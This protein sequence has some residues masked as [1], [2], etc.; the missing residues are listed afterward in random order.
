V[1]TDDGG[2]PRLLKTDYF[3]CVN[4][5]PAS[6]A[7]DFL[8]PFINKFSSRLGEADEN[9]VFFVE[10]VPAGLGTGDDVTS[11]GAEEAPHSAPS[12]MTGVSRRFINAFHWYDG[13]T[14]FIKQFRPWFNYNLKNG[15]I[16]LG[17]KAVKA[18]YL[19]Q[20]SSH[21]ADSMPSIVGEF[22]LPFDIYKGRAFK[23]GDYAVHEEALS[24][25]YD[26]FDA[27]L[28]GCC[29]WAYSADNTFRWGDLWNNEEFSFVT[30]D[31][32][33][34][35]EE[36]AAC[37]L[38]PR[39]QGGWL[40]PYPAATAGTPLEFTWNRKTKKMFFRYKA[41]PA[42]SAPTEIFIPANLHKELKVTV[43]PACADRPE[44]ETEYDAE[45]FR[46]KIFGGTYDGEVAV[47][48]EEK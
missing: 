44:L 35:T 46:L 16:V 29:I 12:R 38:K 20:I 45:K 5:K 37:P 27:L 47:R 8:K 33:G 39:A 30:R 41:S 7:E 14:M 19:E 18:L 40:R 10:G 6:F 4:G 15:K 2:E 43:T 22:G 28:L 34:R 32:A 24:M 21:I 9:A 25:Y 3:S 23:T 26:A 36:I 42:I 17:R 48:A 11:V 31:Y 13:P 1:W